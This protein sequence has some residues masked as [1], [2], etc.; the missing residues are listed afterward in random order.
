MTHEEIK[1]EI[2]ERFMRDQANKAESLYKAGYLEGYRRGQIDQKNKLEC[3][4]AFE[5]GD[6]VSDENGRLAV[7][8]NNDTHIHLLYYWSGKTWKVP[9]DMECK[10]EK[11]GRKTKVSVPIDEKIC[12]PYIH[13][14]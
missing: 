13:E 5:V 14:I 10:L 9:H 7:V 6:E 2:L 11:T 3:G 4:A 1:E 12:P 8:T